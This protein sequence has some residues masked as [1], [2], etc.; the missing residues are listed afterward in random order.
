MRSFTVIFLALTLAYPAFASE[1]ASAEV[2]ELAEPRTHVLLELHA[3]GT[4]D[5]NREFKDESGGISV[6]RSSS[7]SWARCGKGSDRLSRIRSALESTDCFIVTVEGADNQGTSRLGMMF[8][9][10]GDTLKQVLDDGPALVLKRK[11]PSPDQ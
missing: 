9:R 7:G 8:A 1:A 5:F 11:Q 10:D 2:F 3:D 6:F 4:A